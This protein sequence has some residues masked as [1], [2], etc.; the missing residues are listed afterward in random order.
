MTQKHIVADLT[1]EQIMK[2]IGVGMRTTC[3]VDQLLSSR[4]LSNHFFRHTH[5]TNLRRR[6]LKMEENGLVHRGRGSALNDYRWVPGPS[7]SSPLTWPL[8][9]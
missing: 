9:G 5:R 4:L 8:P 7:G 1:D 3:I 2:T 6:L